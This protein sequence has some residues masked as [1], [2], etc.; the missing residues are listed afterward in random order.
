MTRIDVGKQK[1]H[2]IKSDLNYKN[3]YIFAKKPFA[4][5]IVSIAR[6]YPVVNT[7]FEKIFTIKRML[8]KATLNCKNVHSF[9][10]G[11]VACQ[12]RK[13]RLIDLRKSPIL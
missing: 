6:N 5:L 13:V 11:D 7:K 10:N 2:F 8:I 3:V 9:V 12:D 4:K 1:S